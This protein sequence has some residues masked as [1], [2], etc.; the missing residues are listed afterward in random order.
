V[1]LVEPPPN[2]KPGTRISLQ[3]LDVNE[4]EPDEK[5]N[6]RKKN[7]VWLQ[8]AP[9]MATN[10]E[11]LATFDGVKLVTPEGDCTVPTLANCIVK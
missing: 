5:I 9:K 10:G 7:S 11:K 1:E 2:A 3:N 8:F 4:F 6:P